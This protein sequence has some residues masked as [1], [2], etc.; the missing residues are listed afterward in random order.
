MFTEDDVRLDREAIATEQA[1]R[2][3][4]ALVNFTVARALARWSAALDEI[5]RLQAE[6]REANA[7][8]EALENTAWEKSE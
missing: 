5:E 7:R 3:T 6:L 1:C 8:I 4:F 2:Q